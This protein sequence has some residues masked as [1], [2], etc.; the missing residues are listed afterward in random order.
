[1]RLEA[2]GQTLDERDLTISA[3]H[4]AAFAAALGTASAAHTATLVPFFG[5]VVGGQ[6]TAVNGLGLDLSRA[7]LAG[8]DYHWS[9]PFV[10]GETVRSRLFVEDVFTKG[11][12]TFG[13]LVAE[14]T[15]PDGA[16]VQRQSITFI[17]R[18]AQ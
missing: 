16:D 18:G 17:E 12:N 7:L 4:V 3:E 8:I 5:A 6:D 13:V 11:A 2:K 10:V 14:F 1:M 9:R 15:D